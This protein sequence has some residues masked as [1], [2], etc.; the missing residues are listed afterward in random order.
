[1]NLPESVL[2]VLI[3]PE[4][5]FPLRKATIE[6]LQSLQKRHAGSSDAWDEALVCDQGG[7]AYPVRGGFPILL[8][9]ASVG[10]D[11]HP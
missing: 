6:E 4:T 5:R 9:E 7:R 2:A 10:F 3:C 11:S 8:K 1:M